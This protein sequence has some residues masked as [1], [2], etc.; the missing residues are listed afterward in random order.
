MNK[1]CAR[2]FIDHTSVFIIKDSVHAR[3][4][5]AFIFLFSLDVDPREEEEEEGEKKG[6]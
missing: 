1:A 5:D 4:S 2:D 3:Y 6:K